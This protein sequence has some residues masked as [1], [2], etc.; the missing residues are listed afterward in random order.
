MEQL[1]ILYFTHIQFFFYDYFEKRNKT[2][3][4]ARIL[5]Q[6]QSFKK[7]FNYKTTYQLSIALSHT[8]ISFRLLKNFR[9]FIYS[10]PVDKQCFLSKR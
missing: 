8:M 3:P 2:Q 7:H 6:D 4:T 5:K 10:L 9:I 1:C